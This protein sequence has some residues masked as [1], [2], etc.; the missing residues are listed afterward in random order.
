[1]ETE[2]R[3]LIERMVSE[4]RKQVEEAVAKTRERK[5]KTLSEMEEEVSRVGQEIGKELLEGMLD[6]KKTTRR[7][8]AGA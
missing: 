1:M 5:L 3:M 6:L 8:R 7:A 2:D 4:Y